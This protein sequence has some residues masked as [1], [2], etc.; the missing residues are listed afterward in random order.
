M[1]T[2]CL[3]LQ[4][5]WGCAEREPEEQCPRAAAELE[6]NTTTGWPSPL[7]E[8]VQSQLVLDIKEQTGKRFLIYSTDLPRP[9]AVNMNGV[10]L[11]IGRVAVK[12]TRYSYRGSGL[13]SWHPHGS[14]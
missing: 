11:H 12:S 14:S 3:S 5:D 7:S 9:R 13:V 10:I 6:C 1:C 2:N 4:G 8:V